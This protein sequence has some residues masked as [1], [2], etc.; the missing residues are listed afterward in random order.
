[1]KANSFN[2]WLRLTASSIIG[3]IVYHFSSGRKTERLRKMARMR[4]QL[5]ESGKKGEI[6]TL[7]AN[8]RR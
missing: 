1:M 2:L 4:N 8:A 3:A 6:Y 5:K 7:S